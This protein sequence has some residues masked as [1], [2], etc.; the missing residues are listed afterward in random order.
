MARLP[1]FFNSLPRIRNLVYVLLCGLSTIRDIYSPIATT[2]HIS[3][4]QTVYNLIF[5][6]LAWA[7]HRWLN[8]LLSPT[9][10]QATWPGWHR[11]TAGLLG[12][13][14]LLA[15][16]IGSRY[17]IEQV[18][19]PA[20]FGF[21]NYGD[22]TSITYYLTDNLYQLWPALVTAGVLKLIED[23]LAFQRERAELLSQRTVME[24]AYLK[25]QVN[26]HFLF[27]SLNSLSALIGIDPAR[28][29]VFV[30]QLATVYR[31]LLQSNRSGPDAV[32][33][34]NLTASGLAT[35]AD[36][37]AFIRSYSYLLQTRFGDG[38]TLCIDVESAYLG[39][40][41]PAL[42]LQLLVENAIK[43]NVASVRKPLRVE[44][45]SLPGAKLQVRNNLQRKQTGVLSNG[46][47]L[48]NI[49]T[50]YSMLGQPAPI[51]QAD[52]AHF[53]VVVPLIETA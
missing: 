16:V 32:A 33:H 52:A 24:L 26:P 42:T 30:D 4:F 38:F 37:L 19:F 22:E 41:L 34:A 11:C 40:Q 51:I 9:D 49:Q 17:L 44:I 14:V 39:Y 10:K 21:G 18:L 6:T 12:L 8:Y 53:T 25:A 48:S 47:G 1:G 36:E 15:G 28:A 7:T 31:Y 29:E 2:W 3:A 20:W 27:N 43:H 50:K 13:P 45:L 35:A 23:R 46:I 5:W